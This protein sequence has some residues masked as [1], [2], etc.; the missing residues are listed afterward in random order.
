MGAS[1]GESSRL[2]KSIFCLSGGVRDASGACTGWGNPQ[3][4]GLYA[5]ALIGGQCQ[6]RQAVMGRAG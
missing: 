1:C 4:P 6:A 5:Q 3:V 2:D